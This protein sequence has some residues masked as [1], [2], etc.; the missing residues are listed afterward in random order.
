MM[1]I[2]S[3]APVTNF[4]RQDIHYNETQYNNTQKNTILNILHKLHLALGYNYWS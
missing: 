1:S 3:F 2:V 4:E